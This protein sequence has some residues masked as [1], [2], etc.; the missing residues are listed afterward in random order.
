MAEDYDVVIV[1]GGIHGAGIAQAAACAGY[2][3]LVLEKTGLASGSSSRSSK[4]IHGGLRY[5]EG[6]DFSL[7]RESLRERTLLLKIAPDLVHLQPFHIPVYADT[8]RRPLTIRTGL[9][10][11]ALLA[12][13]GPYGRFHTLRRSEWEH[14]DGLDTRGLQVVYRYYDAQ[15]NDVALTRAVMHSA[16]EYG[17][18]LYC[19]AEFLAARITPDGVDI[20]Y[21]NEAGESGCRAGVLVNA[22][23]P[24]INHIADRIEPAAGRIDADLVQGT[25][26]ILEGRLERGC[27]YLEVPVDRRAVFLLTW[28][29]HTLLGTTEHLYRGDPEA[30]M[31][32]AAE[33]VYLLEAMRHYFP[34]RPQQVLERFAGLR[35][36]PGSG[37]SAFQRSRE[38]RLQTDDP[39]RP[40]L[41]WVYGG[42]LTGYRA[43]AH[44][45]MRL[46]RRTLPARK[47]VAHT[48]RL[49][50]TPG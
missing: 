47:V 30:V 15:T 2:R 36:L 41:I 12:G 26:L 8:A 42:K 10:F 5:L 22:A 45:V 32:L 13:L 48:S 19:P 34:R 43:T 35:V 25:H 24:W 46:V 3:A 38:T 33:E 28:G 18:G 20:R 23:G 31:P 37:P 7:V 4:L 27:Y 17:A 49:K 1:G 50:L 39:Q 14:L 6:L 16:M 44:K 11:Y 9:T 29:E 40:R 21:R